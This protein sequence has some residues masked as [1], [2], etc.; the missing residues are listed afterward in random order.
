MNALFH[1]KDEELAAVDAAITQLE[2]SLAR[3]V[4]MD[5]KT[6]KRLYKMGNKTEKFC[7]ETLTL[8]DS[9][10]QLA[11]PAMDLNGA[12]AALATL[13]QLR[14]RTRQILRL[15]ERMQDTELALGSEVATTARRGYKHLQEYGDAHGLEGMRLALAARYKRS[16]RQAAANSDGEDQVA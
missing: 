9:N 11:L 16:G 14:P 8:L 13:D 10:R 4:A 12:L 2:Q 6:R 1:L 3:L 15:A 5:A 7:R